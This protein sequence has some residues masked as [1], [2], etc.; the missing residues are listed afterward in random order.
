MLKINTVKINLLASD[1]A[2]NIQQQFYKGEN[3]VISMPV[4]KYY[5][6]QILNR[7]WTENPN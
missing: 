6:E 7:K 3:A 1:I 5:R 2:Y 4:R